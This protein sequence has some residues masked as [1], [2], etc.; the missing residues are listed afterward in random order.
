MIRGGL[1]K[2][3]V[4]NGSVFFV[5]LNWQSSILTTSSLNDKYV[6]PAKLICLGSDDIQNIS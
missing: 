3:R 1:S 2:G 5:G 4:S 6:L